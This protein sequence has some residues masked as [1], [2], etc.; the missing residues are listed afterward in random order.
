MFENDGICSQY[1]SVSLVSGEKKPSR[2]SEVR[3]EL[4]CGA[5]AKYYVRDNAII[6][7]PQFA[8][9]KTTKIIVLDVLF[10]V[11]VCVFI[12]SRILKH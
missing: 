7:I 9:E 12:V 6:K 2:A 10:V 5:D 8:P 3:S 4:F 11:L 1:G